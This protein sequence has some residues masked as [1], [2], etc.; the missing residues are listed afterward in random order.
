MQ[1]VSTSFRSGAWI[2]A[3]C[4]LAYM[5][6]ACTSARGLPLPNSRR[7]HL[8]DKGAGMT[9]VAREPNSRQA[10]G[11]HHVKPHLEPLYQRVV[12]V[13]GNK[14]H[15]TDSQNAHKA[16]C[17]VTGAKKEQGIRRTGSRLAALKPPLRARRVIRSR[18]IDV[19][20]RSHAVVGICQ[21]VSCGRTVEPC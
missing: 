11:M 19:I 6:P 17:G 4:L 1:V 16:E 3:F 13:H 12:R 8:A 7:K 15:K 5:K 14:D 20:C 18:R 10:R 2:F 21:S 9:H